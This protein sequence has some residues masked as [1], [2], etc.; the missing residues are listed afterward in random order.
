MAL[1]FAIHDGVLEIINETVGYRD[2]SII[3]HLYFKCC[4]LLNPGMISTDK[5]IEPDKKEKNV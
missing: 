1:E 4:C 2:E 5:M 3:W